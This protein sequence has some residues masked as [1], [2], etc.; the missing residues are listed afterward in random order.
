M[1]SYIGQGAPRFF[2]AYNPELPDPS[3][4]K[5]IVLTDNAEARDR[6]KLRLRTQITEGLAPEA[7]HLAGGRRA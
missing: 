6:L 3:F 1:T 7:I 2:L 5:I 4:A